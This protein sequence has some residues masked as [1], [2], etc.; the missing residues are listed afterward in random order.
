MTVVITETGTVRFLYQEDISLAALLG[1][2]V[3]IERASHVEPDEKGQWW[4]RMVAGPVLGPFGRRSDALT[5]EAAW[6]EA[7]TLGS[8]RSSGAP[9]ARSVGGS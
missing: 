6:L 1:G 5:A 7:N 4:A 9:S 3:R 2:S 8:R